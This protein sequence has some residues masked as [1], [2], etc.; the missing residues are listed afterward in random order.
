MA[1]GSTT[2]R[3]SGA[4]LPSNSC[5]KRSSFEYLNSGENDMLS[6]VA[7]NCNLPSLFISGESRNAQFNCPDQQSQE[8]P[9]ALRGFGQI[10]RVCK[11]EW[12]DAVNPPASLIKDRPHDLV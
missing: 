6:E 3:L 8:S 10:Q 12:K 11:S 9:T 7:H 4:S 1:D 5:L 2:Q